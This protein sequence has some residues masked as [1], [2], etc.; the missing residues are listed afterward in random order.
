MNTAFSKFFSISMRWQQNAATPPTF[1]NRESAVGAVIAAAIVARN[2]ADMQPSE[3]LRAA[4][5]AYLDQT[6]AA[7]SRFWEQGMRAP[8]NSR[9][10]SGRTHANDAGGHL[11]ATAKRVVEWALVPHEYDDMRVTAL[12]AAYPGIWG[13]AAAASVSTEW[14]T[15]PRRLMD[16]AC[17]EMAYYDAGAADDAAPAS[18]MPPADFDP[19]A[20]EC[21]CVDDF[22]ADFAEA[23]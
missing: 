2:A 11:V 14:N 4:G 10:G 21:K 17:A 1:R 22:A 7:Y 23:D 20:A 12:M 16:A 6:T 8:A 18:P 15:I 19:Q 13:L 3:L 5:L 9:I